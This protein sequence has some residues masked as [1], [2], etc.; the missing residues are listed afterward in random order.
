MIL[1]RSCGLQPVRLLSPWDFPSKSTEVGYHFLLQG[2][3]FTQGLNRHLLHWQAD[4][5]TLSHQ[6]SPLPT[7]PAHKDVY[8]GR[9]HTRA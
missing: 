4:F 6:G 2:I 9:L 3:Y 1:L 5:L 8:A 7:L